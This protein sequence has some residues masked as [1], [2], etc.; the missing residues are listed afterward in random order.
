MTAANE[1][2]SEPPPP[3]PRGLK[4]EGQV[5]PD[6][7]VHL[8]GDVGEG[9]ALRQVDADEPGGADLLDDLLGAGDAVT[10]A[11]SRASVSASYGRLIM[12]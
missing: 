8:A 6:V 11:W 2:W 7:L 3:A 4:P 5:E 12:S 10:P 9:R 1:E